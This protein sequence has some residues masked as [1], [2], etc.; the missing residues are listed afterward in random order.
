M[1]FSAVL[2]VLMI[3]CFATTSILPVVSDLGLGFVA[4]T[5]AVVMLVAFK[6]E[7]DQFYS[8]VDWDL[9][10]FFASLFIVINVMEHAQVLALL[11]AGIEG[12]IGLG[13]VGGTAAILWSSAVASS[14]TD[15]IPLAAM[16]AKI[17]SQMPADPAPALWWAS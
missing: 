15:N 5:F 3:A 13:E 8:A 10:F 14:V 12:L 17:L 9:I 6:A 11:G 7:V 16:L 1:T 4:T 2:S